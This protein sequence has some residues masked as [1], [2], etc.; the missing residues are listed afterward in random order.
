MRVRNGV[1][2]VVEAVIVGPLA[3]RLLLRHFFVISGGDIRYAG[4]RQ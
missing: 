4:R 1:N 3:S 2:N